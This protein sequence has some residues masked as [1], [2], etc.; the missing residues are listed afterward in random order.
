MH[1]DEIF[2]SS[3]STAERSIAELEG[4]P[5]SRLYWPGRFAK[6]VVRRLLSRGLSPRQVSMVLYLVTTV[7]GLAV[8]LL[9]PNGTVSAYVTIGVLLIVMTGLGESMAPAILGFSML[10]VAW[11]LA[12]A[13]LR[14]TI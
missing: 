7:T 6:R 4:R 2:R 14:R 8:L 12:A 11:I 1:D 9:L 3:L 13:G 5:S 10:T